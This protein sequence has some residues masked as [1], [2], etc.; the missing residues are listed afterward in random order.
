MEHAPVDLRDGRWEIDRPVYRVY[1][2]RPDGGACREYELRKAADVSAVLE[3]ARTFRETAPGLGD[4][5]PEV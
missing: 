3:W 2:S 1:F 4:G 5:V